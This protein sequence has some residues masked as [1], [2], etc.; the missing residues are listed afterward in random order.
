VS[1]RRE[2]CLC[3][4]K[5]N[6]QFE[7]MGIVCLSFCRAASRVYICCHSAFSI[8]HAAK[9][10]SVLNCLLSLTSNKILELWTSIVQTNNDLWIHLCAGSLPGLFNCAVNCTSE[11]KHK[12]Q[13][14][15]ALGRK[16]IKWK[17]NKDFCLPCIYSR[18]S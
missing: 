7:A 8:T 5:L 11:Q 3:S 12:K 15:S 9:L 16:E 17:P 6:I 10:Y 2:S 18:D 4:V 13:M 1:L 14:R